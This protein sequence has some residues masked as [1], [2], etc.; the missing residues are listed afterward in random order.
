MFTTFVLASWTVACFAQQSALAELASPTQ[1]A[2]VY[3]SED[4]GCKQSCDLARCKTPNGH[5]TDYPTVT[6]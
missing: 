4:R 6:R 3:A 5:S 2:A 1:K